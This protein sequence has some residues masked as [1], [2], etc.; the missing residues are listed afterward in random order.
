VRCESS[1][2]AGRQKPQRFFSEHQFTCHRVR[3][4]CG[5]SR[6]TQPRPISPHLAWHGP[7]PSS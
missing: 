1:A 6:R 4:S 7:I 5:E 2:P 3:T